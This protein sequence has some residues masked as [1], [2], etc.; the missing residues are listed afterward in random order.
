MAHGRVQIMN[1]GAPRRFTFLQQTPGSPVY[2]H[3]KRPEVRPDDS[4]HDATAL[5]SAD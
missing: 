3:E 1:H 5:L 2:P 4:G